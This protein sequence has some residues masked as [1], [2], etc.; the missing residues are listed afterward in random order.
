M[1]VPTQPSLALASGA[2]Y[3]IYGV[4]RF[5]HPLEAYYCQCHPGQQAD[6]LLMGGFHGDEPEGITVA[7][8][9]LTTL[10]NDEVIK[11]ALGTTSVVVIPSVNPDGAALATRKNGWLVDINR[12]WPTANW[13]PSLRSDAYHGGAWPLSEPETEALYQLIETAKPRQGILS[14]HTP[15]AE[16][17]TD[18]P[19]TQLEPLA[20]AV[21]SAYQYPITASIGYPTPGSFGTWAGVEQGYPVLTVELAEGGDEVALLQQSYQALL[22]LLRVVA[23]H[24]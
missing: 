2:T 15:Y 1:P 24:G 7:K 18:G 12:N 6:L 10:L 5:G 8:A 3:H 4:S 17:N 21:A 14:L 22:N 16:V 20:Q 23:S 9:W 13:Q 11:T 19:A